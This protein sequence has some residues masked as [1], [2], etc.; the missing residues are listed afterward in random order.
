[1]TPREIL[2]SHIQAAHNNLLVTVCPVCGK[3]YWQAV[4]KEQR[5]AKKAA[6]P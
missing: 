6:K 1:M 2:I 4:T 3:L 5:Q